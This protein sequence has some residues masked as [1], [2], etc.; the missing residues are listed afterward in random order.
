[1]CRSGFESAVATIRRE[2]GPIPGSPRWIRN[3]APAARSASEAGRPSAPTSPEKLSPREWATMNQG[4][5]PAATSV[6]T[7]DP[8]EVPTMKSALP[9]SQS[10]SRASA[11]RPPVSQA[12]PST[13]PAPSTSPTFMTAQV[14]ARTTGQTTR[15]RDSS[16]VQAYS[17]APSRRAGSAQD[18]SLSG[19]R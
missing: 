14:P 13:P 6:P 3:T 11:W 4:G 10:V 5:T 1:M 16:C 12:P 19:S 18:L 15:M 9:G 8:A 2:P 7:I 17:C